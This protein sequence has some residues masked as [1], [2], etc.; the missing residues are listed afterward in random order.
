LLG[1][2]QRLKESS[3]THSPIPP[4]FTREAFFSTVRIF[5]SRIATGFLY[6]ADLETPTY[7]VTNRHVVEASTELTG[8]LLQANGDRPIFGD[9]VEYDLRPT[10][11]SWTFH[12]NRLVDVAVLNFDNLLGESLQAGDPAPFY[13]TIGDW[14]PDDTDISDYNYVEEIS[15]VGYPG[16]IHD[17]IMMTPIVRRGITATPFQIPW[18]GGPAF[19]IDAYV[20]QGSSGSPVLCIHNGMFR[21]GPAYSPGSRAAFLGIL[22]KGIENGSEP[23]TWNEIRS[24]EPRYA[25]LGVVFKWSTI[26]ETIAESLRT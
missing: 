21:N 23:A 16:G 19:L 18:M 20:V 13:S 14:G 26:S 8:A 10:R 12:P 17:T 4:D 15:F 1:T 7:L 11:R 6:Q 3:V 9:T 22:G 24:R 25:N 2:A 5:G